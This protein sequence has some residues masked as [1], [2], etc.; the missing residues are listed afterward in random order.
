M[1]DSAVGDAKASGRPRAVEAHEAP[2][3]GAAAGRG[4][5][6]SLF[7]ADGTPFAAGEN[8]LG[9]LGQGVT[10]FDIPAPLAVEAPQEAAPVVAVSAGL[11]HA[12]LL[13]AEGDVW[14]WGIGNSGRLGLGDE[15]TRTV[16]E[17]IGGALDA[18]DVVLV[19]LGNGASYAVTQDGALW[20]WGQNTN[21][22][23]GLGDREERMV[24]TRV[25]AVGEV[26]AVSS[27]TSRT[28]AL[29]AEG[30]VLAWGSNSRGQIGSPEGLDE[31]EPVR[32]VLDPM[33]VEGLPDGVGVAAITADTN[34]SY[35]VL[36]D[37]RVFGWGE[38]SFGQLLQ[39]EPTAEGTFIPAEDDALAPVELVDLPPDVVDVKG[40]ARWAAALAA[41][42]EVW[43]WGPD[44]G[45]PTGGLDSDPVLLWGVPSGEDMALV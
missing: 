26:V 10:G 17:K 23:L 21:G 40:G 14:S 34:T 16:R 33:A 15:E 36:E 24:P 29:T 19:E 39:G 28:P 4:N 1:T 37:G 13:D 20:A 27:G 2:G 22:Q 35:A 43:L 12:A 38:G 44:D 8:L 9:Q 31:G 25:E 3:F 5:H 41:G 30:R 42:G 6:Y 45:G 7:L 11:I 18:L 32:R